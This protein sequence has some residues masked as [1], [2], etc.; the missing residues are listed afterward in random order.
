MLERLLPSREQP[1]KH[2][3]RAALEVDI[4]WS[5]AST[6]FSP[7]ECPSP[8]SGCSDFASRP[9]TCTADG[10]FT[11]GVT[12]KF[13]NK[14]LGRFRQQLLQRYLSL[15]D[16]FSRLD[17]T[18]S[19]DKALTIK[20][21]HHVLERLGV[22]E[23]D[24][25]EL[26]A[27]MDTNS[28]GGVSLSEFLH[29]LVD[30]SPEALLW[31]LRCRLIRTGITAQNLRKAVEL[32][33]W[34][35]HGW[36]SKATE[37]KR[38]TNRRVR[39]CTACA[40]CI[41][42]SCGG[43][44]SETGEAPDPPPE[45]DYSLVHRP[46]PPSSYHLS[47]GDWLKFCTS[48][49]LTLLEAERLFTFLADVS[50]MVDLREMFET[51]RKTVEPDVSLERFT[52][53]LL[54]RYESVSA[55]FAS[56]CQDRDT[57][58]ERMLRWDGF[59]AMAISLNVNDRNAAKLWDVLTACTWDGDDLT[60]DTG[61]YERPPESCIT[62]GAFIG[63]LSLWAPE[64]ALQALEGEMCER[65]GNLA[66]GQRVL[67]KHLTS[68]DVLS[69]RDLEYRLRAVGI[70]HCDVQ[71]ALRTVASRHNEHGGQ[72]SLDATIST[73]RA[74]RRTASKVGESSKCARSAIK[75][76]TLPLWEQLRSHQSD[77]AKPC[78]PTDGTGRSGVAVEPVAVHR[79]HNQRAPLPAGPAE[80]R[81]FAEAVHG[82]VKSAETSRSRFVLQNAHRQVVRLEE[83]WAAGPGQDSPVPPAGSA[84]LAGAAAGSGL[85]RTGCTVSR[86]SSSCSVVRPA[87]SESTLV[88]PLS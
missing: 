78:T 35:Q 52:T 87:T 85:Q 53:K 60:Q 80:R 14:L 34:P 84:A 36:Q 21:F 83:R 59:H 17:R 12:R 50:G 30:I 11:D 75:H 86:R 76:D 77:L 47:R 33:R 48:V 88:G 71:R 5:P 16:A 63:Q 25:Q 66:E 8:L 46:R 7:E 73:M 24:S 65:F 22:G 18:A 15:H 57:D 39:R 13:Q 2:A 79:E 20:E 10:K 29:A 49:C 38:R 64:T 31:E 9:S 69:L 40:S 3:Q 6:S 55:A 41:G 32:V 44:A 72:V 56:F 82:A 19:R 68:K 4:T 37:L 28:D 62:E 67:E 61:P 43:T 26:F 23:E 27:A 58:P 81:K 51:L 42:C 70:K 1:A 74:A 45:A 54:A